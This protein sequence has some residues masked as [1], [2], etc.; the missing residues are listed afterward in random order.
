MS[1]AC[2]RQISHLVELLAQL[3]ILVNLPAHHVR[4]FSDAGNKELYI[5]L[6]FMLGI[7]AMVF[8]RTGTCGLLQQFLNMLG[9][10]AGYFCDFF[11]SLGLSKAHFQH[12]FGLFV[13]FQG[14]I[15]KYVFRILFGKFFDP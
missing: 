12:D 13:T 9:I 3:R 5:I 8:H 14:T 6:L 1:L 2:Q 10:F 4:H 7:L 15:Q 11:Q